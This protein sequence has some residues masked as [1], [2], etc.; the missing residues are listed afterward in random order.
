[1]SS[2]PID[3]SPVRR[4]GVS[5]QSS[6]FLASG[7]EFPAQG[8]P[9]IA[10][11]HAAARR[12]SQH[13]PSQLRRG[14]SPTVLPLLLRAPPDE[15]PGPLTNPDETLRFECLVCP[16]HGSRVHAERR[17]QMTHGGKDMAWGQGPSSDGGPDSGGDLLVKGGWTAV[18]D[19][20]EHPRPPYY[21]IGIL[22]H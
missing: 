13:L 5:G 10:P 16:D 20:V 2:R 11:L 17:G 6:S 22:I 21:C 1:M 4:P 3:L 12:L 7:P 9:K 19:L 14:T 18:I 8:R 15:G